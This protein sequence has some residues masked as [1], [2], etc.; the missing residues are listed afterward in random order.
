MHYD[1]LPNHT[2]IM[3]ILEYFFIFILF[4][5]IF[6]GLPYIKYVFLLPSVTITIIIFCMS[7]IF[8]CSICTAS[9]RCVAVWII[10]FF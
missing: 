4:Y 5:F 2:F 3:M 8:A 1:F 6:T 10:T 9:L 7:R